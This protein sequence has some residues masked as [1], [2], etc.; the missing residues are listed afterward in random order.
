MLH[1]LHRKKRT[2]ILA[3]ATIL[4]DI[5]ANA[6]GIQNV[7]L[8]NYGNFTAGHSISSLLATVDPDLDASI[9]EDLAFV[10][11]TTQALPLTFDQVITSSEND[12]WQE[13][14]SIVIK[15]QEVGDQLV[16]AAAALGLGT[17]ALNSQNKPIG[18]MNMKL[19][20][21]ILAV[22][23]FSIASC[24]PDSSDETKEQPIIMLAGDATIYDAGVNAYSF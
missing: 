23:G 9:K 24:N 2:S 22:L 6:L 18:K 4:T 19:A 15:L 3:L 11:S 20:R 16:E 7:Y 13:L 21:A 10:L 14:N 8:G 17:I 12:G 5:Y 1:F